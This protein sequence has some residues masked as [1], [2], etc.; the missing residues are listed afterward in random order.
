MSP[1]VNK[2]NQQLLTFNSTRG[3]YYFAAFLFPDLT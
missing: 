2:L 1:T 3:S